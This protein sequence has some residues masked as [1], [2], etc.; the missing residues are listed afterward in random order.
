MSS[1]ALSAGL[2]ALPQGVAIRDRFVRGASPRERQ[3]RLANLTNHN[4]PYEQFL[5]SICLTRTRLLSLFHVILPLPVDRQ[6]FC[7][8]PSP[9]R[10]LCPYCTN[11]RR[12]DARWRH[13][14]VVGTALAG[15]LSAAA[16]LARHKLSPCQDIVHT[17]R[18]VSCIFIC[19]P[20][21]FFR[22]DGR[23]SSRCD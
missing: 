1:N 16:L 4:D 23:C 10:G 22:H 3:L 15:K 20:G 17:D 5:L 9:P 7:C 11:S 6:S 14:P 13:H 18:L 19:F 8:H 21:P 12:D 2:S